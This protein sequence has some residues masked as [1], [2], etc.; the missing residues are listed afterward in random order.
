MQEDFKPAARTSQLVIHEL[1]DELLVYDL[2]SHRAHCLNAPAKLVCDRRRGNKTIS[3]IATA[4][5]GLSPEAVSFAVDQLGE[6]RLLEQPSSTP[7]RWTKSRREAIRAIGKT[8]A[9]ALPLIVSL[10]APQSSMAS[11]TACAC[12]TSAICAQHPQCPAMT[13]NANGLCAP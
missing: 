7:H 3:E 5:P 9:A 11:I 12:T 1:P 10:T 13:C 8:A 6:R 4:L 2:E